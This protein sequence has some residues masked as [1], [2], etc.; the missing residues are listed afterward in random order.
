MQIDKDEAYYKQRARANLLQLGD[1]NN[2]FFYRYAFTWKKVN[3]IRRLEKDG[4]G[5]IANID[6]IGE[7]ASTYFQNLFTSKGVSDLSH[8]LSSIK[9]IIDS[10]ANSL[11]M[12]SY[13][14]DE[15]FSAIKE[16]SLM[17]APR[18]D[19]SRLYFL[20][21]IGILWAVK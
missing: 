4:G 21:V 6:E 7:I 18:E 12:A 15:I 13:T 9:A 10:K 5:E 1:R 16:M 17:K 20:N 8:A 19:V 2:N 3:L 14:E 11:L